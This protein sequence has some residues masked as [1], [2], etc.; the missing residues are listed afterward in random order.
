M[1]GVSCDSMDNLGEVMIQTLE[2]G[3]WVYYSGVGDYSNELN[4]N[5]NGFSAPAMYYCCEERHYN[6][7]EGLL[8]DN[9]NFKKF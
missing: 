5:F 8:S 1:W 3:D 7:L 4:T 2:E 9:F 6:M